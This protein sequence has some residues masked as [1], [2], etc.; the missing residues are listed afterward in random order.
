MMHEIG[1]KIGGALAGSIRSGMRSA[2]DSM[3]PQDRALVMMAA[4]AY[5]GSKFGGF[6][7]L[8]GAAVGAIGGA[9]YS[10]ENDLREIKQD[11]GGVM[12]RRGSRKE[13]QRRYNEAKRKWQAKGAMSEEI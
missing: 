13:T 1:A 9:G 11:V 2:I 12:G 5:V 10:I 6:G 3:S 8:A 7:M 4:G